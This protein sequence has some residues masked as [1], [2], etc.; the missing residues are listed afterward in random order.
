ML[1]IWKAVLQIADDQEIEV[2]SGAEFLTVREQHEAPCLWF[3]CSPTAPRTVKRR[4]RLCGTGH[5]T[6]PMAH[7]STYLGTVSLSGGSLIFHAFEML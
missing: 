5:P 2:P 3:R 4:I 6:A 1:T 7:N